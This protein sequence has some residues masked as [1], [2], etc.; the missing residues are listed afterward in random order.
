V[1]AD[2][3]VECVG[4]RVG[5]GFLGGADAEGAGAGGAGELVRTIFAPAAARCLIVV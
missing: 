1:G 3:I 4:E 5:V 2:D